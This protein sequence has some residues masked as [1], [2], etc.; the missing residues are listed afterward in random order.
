MVEEEKRPCLG[1]HERRSI[2]RKQILRLAHGP[3]RT[4]RP[5]ILLVALGWQTAALL[6]LV[7]A[8]EGSGKK[9]GG[10]SAGT[11]EATGRNLLTSPQKCLSKIATHLS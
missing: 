3:Q 6:Y 2:G 11:A 10:E 8:A 4:G 1:S 7:L 9:K 5:L